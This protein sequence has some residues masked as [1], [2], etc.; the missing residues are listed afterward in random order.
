MTP[1][2]HCGVVEVAGTWMPLNLAYLAASAKKAGYDAF[3]YD[4]M[5]LFHNFSQI[6]KTLKRVKPDVLAL[7]CI[8]ATFPAVLS[9]LRLAKKI[10]PDVKTILG[11]VHPTF[12]D[13]EIFQNDGDAVD[14][15]V[16]G[17]GEETFSDL[18][19]SLNNGG[20][21]DVAGISFKDGDSVFSN[22]SFVSSQN[23]DCLEPAWETINWP[24]YTYYVFPR[25][26]LAVL[27][28]SRGCIYGC[29]FCSQQKFWKK[30]WRAKSPEKVSGQIKFLHDK[31][32]VDVLLLSDEYPTADAGRWEELLDR[33]IFEKNPVVLLM[34]T[35]ADDIVRDKAVLRKYKKAGVLHVYVGVEAVAQETL[36]KFNKS[37][38]VDVSREALRLLHDAGMI[39]ETSFVLGAPWETKESIRET[40]ELAKFYDPDFA[41]FLA[42][43]PWPYADMYKNLQPYIR[44]RDYAKYNLVEAVIE[45]EK[46][47]LKEINEAIVSC[48]KEF[49]MHRMKHFEKYVHPVKRKYFL[50]SMKL[51]M[52]SSFLRKY[53][54]SLGKMPKEIERKLAVEEKIE[55]LRPAKAG[56]TK[57]ASHEESSRCDGRV[58]TDARRSC[59]RT[60][61]TDSDHTAVFTHGV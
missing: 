32:G 59:V 55:F 23:L 49:Y 5:S 57:E 53:L 50:A 30:R 58:L 61:Q 47:T 54:P 4:A 6:E 39:T 48:Y 26:R 9:V 38:K 13:K 52:K 12:C 33:L 16:R 21:H 34:E 22:P 25:S 8:T 28:S 27:D 35:R 3:V 36:D 2:Y 14:F 46:M 15:I 42:L 7:T 20:A 31:Y 40:L 19:A 1:P 44:S 51:I 37:L 45:P 29:S 24:L 56:N 11:G 60:G 18:L 17:E 43:A 10:N 41:H